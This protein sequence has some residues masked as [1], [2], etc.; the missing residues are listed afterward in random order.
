MN[1]V[2]GIMSFVVFLSNLFRVIGC[3]RGS[4][5]CDSGLGFI[6]FIIMLVAGAILIFQ[7]ATLNKDERNWYKDNLRRYYELTIGQCFYYFIYMTL[8]V[9]QY[10]CQCSKC[11]AG[12]DDDYE[13]ESHRTI[14]A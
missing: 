5:W 8:I 1:V 7:V 10:I 3:T 11:C 12:N 14:Y 6:N 13:L 9:L 2:V 4:G